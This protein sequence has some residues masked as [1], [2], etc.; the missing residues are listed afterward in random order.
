MPKERIGIMGGSF[1]PIHE[2]HVEMAL[3]AKEEYGLDRLIFLPTGN[4]P[5][6]RE[7]LAGAEE[8]F[9]MTRLA[10]FGRPG[11][12][13]SRMEV[14]RTGVIYTVDTLSA[15]QKQMPDAELNYI[16]GE[17]TLMNLPN[18]RKPDKVFSMCRF[19]VCCRTSE[20]IEKL[21]VVQELCQRGGRFSFLSLPP[22]QV[23]ATVARQKVAA[24]EKAEEL[25]PQVR[26]YIR[27]MGLYGCQPLIPNG[28]ETYTRLKQA[29][30]DKRLFHSLLVADTA[31]Q[32]ALLH[33]VDPQKAELAGLLH[34]SAKCL[35][36][37][38]M[39]RL[40]RQQRLL[41][42][43]ETLQSGN[44]L[45]GPAGAVLAQEEYGVTDPNILSAIR[46]HTTG[47]VGMLP[48]DL[49]VY[50]ADKIEPS[51]RA[52][53]ALEQARALADTNLAAAAR[54]LMESS[55]AYVRSQGGQ[56]H[57]VTQQA[58]EW[59]KRLDKSGRNK[60]RGENPN[61]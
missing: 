47:K 26:E 34:D 60:E 59:L 22:S 20:D 3:A 7:G 28:R 39:Q 13:A 44:L 36:F 32:L 49:I 14:E 57:P 10:V 61:E 29:L 16:I 56:P 58:A 37:G 54:Q 27:V 41:L 40:V 12:V 19:L 50:L 45:H 5:H 35:P 46:C 53:P 8:R 9:E 21:P 23:S 51:R 4:P 11:C 15:M 1:N 52:Y 24:G 6:K 55:M 17:D 25:A 43:R 48:L 31:R 38:E 2:R 30:S 33:G 42:D 18:W